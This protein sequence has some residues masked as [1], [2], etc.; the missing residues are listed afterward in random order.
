M[1]LGHNVP[2]DS[3]IEI[4]LTNAKSLTSHYSNMQNP[5]NIQCTD[6]HIG[7]AGSKECLVFFLN[8]LLNNK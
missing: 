7:D 6:A 3:A 2:M 4:L 5:Q 8:K 1:Y